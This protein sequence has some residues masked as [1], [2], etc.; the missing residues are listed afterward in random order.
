MNKTILAMLMFIV[1]LTGVIIGI[2]T[3]ENQQ[4]ANIQENN[5]IKNENVVNEIASNDEEIYDDCT[6][7][8]EIMNNEESKT[9]TLQVN[10]GYEKEEKNKFILRDM[11]GKIVIY[12]ID[13]DGEEIEY[14]LT[15]IAT[16]YL[17]EEDKQNLRN[18]I[19][20]SGEE[21]LNQLLEDFE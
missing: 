9:E 20:V 10:S 5:Q 2:N 1:I 16:D 12:K 21:A 7:E 17:A 13:E 8:W 19:T 14:D 18:G 4:Y 11:Y 6:D 3:Y 15:D